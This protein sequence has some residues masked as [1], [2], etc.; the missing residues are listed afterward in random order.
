[1]IKLC[2]F[3]ECT[4]SLFAMP[5]REEEILTKCGWPSAQKA[6]EVGALDVATRALALEDRLRLRTSGL[7]EVRLVARALA[8]A[9][10]L[11]LLAECGPFARAMRLLLPRPSNAPAC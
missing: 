4:P 10:A 7:N 8:K 1:M 11:D 5:G 9:R 3:C 6:L 2:R